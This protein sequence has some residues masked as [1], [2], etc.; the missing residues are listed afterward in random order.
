MTILLVI[1]GVL[2]AHY[3]STMKEGIYAIFQTLMA[4]F[5]GPALAVL[6]TG[7]FWKRAT[8][9]G[10]FTGFITGICCSVSLYAL[11][12][13]TVYQFLGNDPLFQIPEP[14]LYFSIWA[15]LVALLVIVIVSFLS[16]PEPEEKLHYLYS[17]K[18]HKGKDA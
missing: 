14:F 13:P 4:F 2:F 15:F 8:G 7:L 16:S 1:W 11:N 18:F 17:R 5:Q 12:H 3:I 10:A 6:L 9:V